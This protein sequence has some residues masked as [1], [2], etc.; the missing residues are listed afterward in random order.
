MVPLGREIAFRDRVVERA[1]V[2]EHQCVYNEHQRARWDTFLQCSRVM[3]N[4]MNFASNKAIKRVAQTIEDTIFDQLVLFPGPLYKK[5][6]VQRVLSNP[7]VV[8]YIPKH[9]KFS[10]HGIVEQKLILGLVQ[11]LA[12]LK[13]SNWQ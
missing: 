10:K 8:S 4:S 7:T 13:A 12:K 3:Q 6:V 9:F 1:Q 2:E 11:S 5:I